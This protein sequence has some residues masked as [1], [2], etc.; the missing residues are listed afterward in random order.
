MTYTLNV[1]QIKEKNADQLVTIELN[2]YYNVKTSQDQLNA[3]F[4]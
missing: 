2:R 4:V 1:T 3:L